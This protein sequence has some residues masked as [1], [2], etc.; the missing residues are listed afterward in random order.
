MPEKKTVLVVTTVERVELPSP[1]IAGY[2]AGAIN[3]T[4]DAYHGDWSVEE[5]GDHKIEV[6][7]EVE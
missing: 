6:K 1:A 7:A 2:I 3:R 4:S 5:L